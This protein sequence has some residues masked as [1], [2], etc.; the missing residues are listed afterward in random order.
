MLWQR[1]HISC[2]IRQCYT[3]ILLPL[4]TIMLA[5]AFLQPH[6]QPNQGTEDPGEVVPF[7]L[8]ERMH[9]ERKKEA[10]MAKGKM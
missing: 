7:S 3:F 9:K 5:Q 6:S 4:S 8:P 1:F 2:N 10:K